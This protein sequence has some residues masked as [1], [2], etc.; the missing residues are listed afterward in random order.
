MW[1]RVLTWLRP[2][3]DR[4]V[5]IVFAMGFSSG[6]PFMLS[7]ST[8]SYWL[9]KVGVSNTEIGLFALVG[10]SYNF[11]FLWSPLF[12]N[13][14]APWIGRLGRRRAWGVLSQLGLIA[15]LLL[16]GASDPAV[17]VL[18]TALCAVL[19]AFFSASLDIVVDAYRVEILDEDRQGPGA[20]ATQLGYRIGILTSGAGGLFLS[21][22]LD[23]FAV[24]AVMAAL[25]GLG[26]IL[27]LVSPEPSRAPAAGP[28]R[29]TPLGR[30]REAIIDPFIDFAKRK[31]WLAILAFV[32]LFKLGDAFA[33]N[34][35]TPFYVQMGFTA[36]EIASV[37]KVFGVIA[38]ML[39][40]LVGGA[41]I[42]RVTLPSAL[43][44]AGILQLASNWMFAAQ[45]LVGHS[46]PFLM[47]TIFTENFT[48]GVGAAAFV[49][50]LS[51]LCTLRYTAT[52]Y[53]LLSSLA[54]FGRTLL[55]SPAGWVADKV[56]W[57]T[58]FIATSIIAVPGLLLLV[59]L[60]RT[61]KLGE[62][63]SAPA[64]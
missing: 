35:A 45:A 11:K 37:T 43:L 64:R 6:L 39:G 53:A 32:I 31:S 19:I 63:A 14:V 42:V 5:L 58:F 55:S 9:T 25:V 27:L 7:G 21:D 1:A 54:A 30:L 26:V 61:V 57:V 22:Y 13:V 52:H 49:A 60:M 16:T 46:V 38:T 2:Y 40:I 59:Y 56:D 12:D 20:A 34:M 17:S 48:S 62:P 3:L 24:Y 10:L 44:V 47:L 23:W 50:Y 15:A 41:L 28:T 51:S 33:S 29:P 4:R 18:H 8:L 36:K